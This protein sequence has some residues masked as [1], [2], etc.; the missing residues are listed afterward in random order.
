MCVMTTIRDSRG[1]GVMCFRRGARGQTLPYTHRPC[2]WVL[3]K[4]SLES[5]MLYARLL[6]KQR[7]LTLPERALLASDSSLLMCPS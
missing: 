1:T 4:A 3:E 2:P 5:C 7:D 6:A